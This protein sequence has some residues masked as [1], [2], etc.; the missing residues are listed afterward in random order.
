[1]KSNFRERQR[2]LKALAEEVGDDFLSGMASKHDPAFTFNYQLDDEYAEP[3]FI[4]ERFAPLV[5]EDRTELGNA[6]SD[7]AEKDEEM[8]AALPQ[9]EMGWNILARI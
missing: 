2:K 6:I 3:S 4:D 1:M 9:W 5:S 8:R 7:L